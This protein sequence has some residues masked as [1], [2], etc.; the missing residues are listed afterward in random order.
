MNNKLHILYVGTFF[1]VGILV[2][3]LLIINGYTY[4][5]T[6]IEERFFH[7]QNMLLKPSGDLGH[8]LGIIGTL[9]MIVGVSTYMVRKRYRKLFNLGY[10]KHWLEFHIFLCSVGPVL[11]L[12]HTAFKFGGIVSVSFWS[13]VAVV[14][15]GVIGRF[16]YIQIPRSIE[17]QELT[18]KELG[19]MSDDLTFRL[20]KEY[21]ING[22]IALKLE[23]AF[24]SDRYKELSIWSALIVVVKE[25]FGMYKV[26]REVRN[27]LKVLNISHLKEKQII[28]ITKSKLNLMR[29]IGMMRTMQKLFRYWHIAHLPFAIIMFVIMIIHVGVTIAFGY[30]W[31]F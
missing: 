6:P 31:I 10:L 30:K 3:A 16:I 18:V 14:A 22:S 8:G 24:A 25:Y 15:S 28:E 1:V 21:S 4:Y 9:M 11:V 23:K 12:F 20:K 5:S 7:A 2:T 17:G 29:R 26:L 19:A 13:M 27:D